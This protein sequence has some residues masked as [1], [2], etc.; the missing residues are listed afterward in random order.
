MNIE[1]AHG[2]KVGLDWQP[3]GKNDSNKI[4]RFKSPMQFIPYFSNDLRTCTVFFY[5]TDIPIEYRSA[6]FIVSDGTSSLP[7]QIGDMITIEPIIDWLINPGKFNLK[8][9]WIGDKE[10]EEYKK[11]VQVLRTLKK[12]QP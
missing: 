2:K 9:H 3:K 1:K 7:L 11:L 6:T 5:F 10:C 12:L 4:S 8:N